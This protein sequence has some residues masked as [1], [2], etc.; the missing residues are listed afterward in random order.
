MR[1]TLAGYRH[2]ILGGHQLKWGAPVL[3]AG[4]T[5]SYAIVASDVHSPG[6]RNCAGIGPI[7][8]LLARSG[9]DAGAVARELDAAFRSWERV[10]DI[11]FVQGR[12]ADADILIGAQLEPVGYAFANVDYDRSPGAGPRTLSR[13]LVCLNPERPWKI[14]FDGDLEIYDLRYTFIHEIGHAIGLDHPAIDG[15]LMAYKYG[16]TFRDPQPGDIAGIER[17]YGAPRGGVPVRTAGTQAT[18]A[19]R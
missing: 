16:E 3:G 18:A 11:R 8:G 19:V 2:L 12:P 7:A 9:L 6:A 5:V 4:A 10:A 14:G 17:L 13:S 1:P 15:Q